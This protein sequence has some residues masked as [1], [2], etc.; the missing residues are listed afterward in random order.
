IKAG[1]Y[2]LKPG[3]N[4]HQMLLLL[5]SGKEMRLT[6]QFIEGTRL[7]DWLAVLAKAPY[8]K[9]TITDTSE[10]GIAKALNISG[11]QNAEGWFY[12]DTYQYTPYSTDIELL[13]RAYQKMQKELALVWQNRV[14]DL[15]YKTPYEL[16][17]MSSIIEKETGLDEERRLV[18]SVFINRLKRGMRLQT[19]PTVIYGIKDRYDGNIR[20]KDLQDNNAY[21]T[22]LISGLPPTPIAMPSFASLQAAAKPANTSYLYFVATGQHG[23]HKFT[24]TLQEH[25]QA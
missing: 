17:I 22:Y 15:P 9:Q 25:N 5:V 2:L 20:R 11:V 8:L 24:A 13:N 1:T 14:A 12:P 6:V 10:Q 7:S 23:K 4:I 18:A 21:N 19:D 3:M 16:L